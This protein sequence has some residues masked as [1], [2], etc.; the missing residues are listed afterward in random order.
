MTSFSKST[1]ITSFYVQLYFFLFLLINIIQ[2]PLACHG[3][4]EQERRALLDFKFSLEDPANRLASWLEGS[5]YRNC[6]SWQGVG[7]S[8]DSS[9]VI[10]INL[11]NTV[12]ETRY[13]EDPYGL[14]P[15]PNT[16]LKGNFSSSLVNIANLVY[17]D[18]AFN[19]FQESQIPFQFSALTKLVHLDLS[20]SNFSA[21]ASAQFTNLSSLLYLD[22]S[23][24]FIV[25]LRRYD[26]ISSCLGSSSMKWL[27]GSANLQVLKLSGIDLYEATS[28][29]KNFAESISYL[30]NLKDLH[31]SSCNISSTDFPIHEFHNLSR[32][33]SL[34]LSVNYKMS[35]EVPTQMVNLTSLSILDVSSC[36]LHG[37]VPYLPQLTELDV[38]F[39]DGLHPDFLTKMFQRRWPKLQRLSISSAYIGGPIPNSISNAPVL[40]TLSAYSCAIQGSL[41]SSIYGLTLL[42]SIDL[43]YN[44]ITGY[45]HSSIC[46]ISSL[47]ELSLDE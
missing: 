40:V 36:G 34:K 33:S 29:E 20:Y 26:L 5:K 38:S 46:D 16:A 19:N 47:R 23:C 27:R 6:C 21:S 43:R 3:C 15:P 28:S 45:I 35:F 17:V 42:N 10:S 39:N 12:L 2:F 22:L 31:L 13:N 24:G 37:S 44:N 4:Q 32:L 1:Q 30:S 11:R 9:R 18:L 41:P 25:R 8:S 7:C 14:V